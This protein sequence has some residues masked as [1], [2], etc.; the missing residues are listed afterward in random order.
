MTEWGG[1]ETEK[2]REGGR[3]E[4]REEGKKRERERLIERERSYPDWKGK[5]YFYFH[6]K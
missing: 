2:K 5:N 1:M 4:G 6:V 3:E